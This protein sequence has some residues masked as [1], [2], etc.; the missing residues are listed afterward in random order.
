RQR[1]DLGALLLH[2]VEEVE[3]CGRKHLVMRRGAEIILE[4]AAMQARRGIVRGHERN[5]IALAGLADGDRNGAL[6]GTKDGTDLFLRDQT[7]GLSAALLRVALMVGIDQANLGAAEARQT[8]TPGERKIEV[9]IVV[10][11]V[12]RGLEGALRIDADLRA[13]AR[14]RI[15]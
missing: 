2:G 4:T 9:L 13:G 8:G 3:H 11:D 7:L 14:Q 5:L 15:R 10:D 6:G 12:D 1:L